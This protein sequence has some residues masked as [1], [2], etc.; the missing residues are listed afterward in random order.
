M[1]HVEIDQPGAIPAASTFSIQA[2]MGDR[3]R[4]ETSKLPDG[5]GVASNEDRSV[6]RQGATTDGGTRPGRATESA[7]MVNAEYPDLAVVS[8][9]WPELPEAV[10]AGIVAMVK[11]ATV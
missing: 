2:S 6:L 9:A 11:A 7:T 10:R 5:E 8:A 1:V 3:R 4:Q